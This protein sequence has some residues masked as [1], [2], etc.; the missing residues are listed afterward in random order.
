MD[1]RIGVRIEFGHKTKRSYTAERSQYKIIKAGNGPTP[2]DTDIVET[3]SIDG[4]EFDSSAI[5][6]SSSFPMNGVMKGWAEALKWILYIPL[7]CGVSE[8]RV[9]V[10]T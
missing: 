5:G 3:N 7:G 1:V 4:K 8:M 6:G 2:K 9:T 10:T